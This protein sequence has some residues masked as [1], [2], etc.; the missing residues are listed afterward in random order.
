VLAR[1]RQTLVPTV[2]Q[3]GGSRF[4]NVAQILL[5]GKPG[6]RSAFLFPERQY[7]YGEIIA[8]STDVAKFLV[9][10][11]GRK[12]DRVI[13]VSENSFFWVSAYLGIL[14]AGMVCVPLP[15]T[16]P[17]DDLQKILE[18][19]EPRFAFLEGKF[20]T[21][22]VAQFGS[23]LVV[24]DDHLS[25]LPSTLQSLSFSSL[26]AH[27]APTS[28]T[29]PT[30]YADD[31]AALMFTSGSTGT[32]RGVMVSHGN[33]IANTKSI[34]QYMG[35]TERD[36]IM[37][38]LPF[39]YCFGTSLLHTHLWVGGSLVIDPRFMYPEKV[40]Q[41]MRE[42]QCTGFAG[43]PSH[44]QILLRRSSLRN[45][46]FPHLR[47]VQQAGGHLAPAFIRELRDLLPTTQIFIMYGQTE[48]TARLSYLPPELLDRKLGSIG[49]GVPGVKLCVINESGQE[50][51]PGEVGEIVAEGKNV[52]R[53]YW[54]DPQESAAS[55]RDGRL[56][57]GDLAT[58]DQ[59]G[60]IYVVDRARDF[61][62]CGGRRVSCRQLEEQMLACDALLEAAVV[63]IQD[64]TLGEAVKVFIVPRD[65]D[66]N[67]LSERLREFCKNRIPLQLNPREIVVLD[68]LPKNSAG[69]VMK[70]ALKIMSRK[71][72]EPSPAHSHILTS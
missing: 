71:A 69:K 35:L 54:R 70:S 52:A 19:T 57:T 11:G 4:E 24:T 16:L 30:V 49:K 3:S 43:V 23:L 38:V 34:I 15:P 62:K 32:P 29:L 14:S 47:Y 63:G 39:Y 27:V 17:S 72:G 65:H 36:R 66:S 25:G 56:H 8:A 59:D 53:G 64:D 9:R 37:T 22:N 5:E 28:V 68:A 18:A 50:V 1:Q 6:A 58:V 20:A 60:F 41:R 44:Y 51:A 21:K 7:T 40:V 13:L 46:G 31:L 48:A 42:T 67:L 26:P 55:F 2:S 33:I 10:V 12:C 61:I 45:M